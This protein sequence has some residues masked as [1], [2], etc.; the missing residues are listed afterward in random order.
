MIYLYIELFLFGLLLICAPGMLYA[1]YAA[2]MNFKRV[3]EDGKAGRGPG[4]TRLQTVC[5]S[6]ILARGYLLDF[7]VNTVHMTVRL[8]ELPR[9]L[10]VTHRLRRHIEGNTKHAALCLSYRMELDA[11]D[12]SGI[13]R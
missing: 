5:G 11:L 3:R 9:E 4:L 12:P 10:T 7:F 13:H 2:V 1:D 8:R 6:Y